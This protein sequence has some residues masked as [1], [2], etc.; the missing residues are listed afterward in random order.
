MKKLIFPAF[1]AASFLLVG[2]FMHQAGVYQE[3]T[4]W[5]TQA[6][7]HADACHEMLTIGVN[8]LGQAEVRYLQKVGLATPW[9]PIL[10]ECDSLDRLRKGDFQ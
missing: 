1:I 8:Q 5:I 2:W 4:R 7:Y 9:H 10:L 6:G 3:R